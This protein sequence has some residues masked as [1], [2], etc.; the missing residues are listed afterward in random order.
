[1]ANRKLAGF[2]QGESSSEEGDIH[3]LSR[4]MIIEENET[5]ISRD[6]NRIQTPNLEPHDLNFS[7]YATL[8]EK[9]YECDE[10]KVNYQELYDNAQTELEGLRQKLYYKSEELSE[11]KV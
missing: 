6:I 2:E 4:E 11:L 9:M 7:E 5:I 3:N 8:K 1:M 10:E